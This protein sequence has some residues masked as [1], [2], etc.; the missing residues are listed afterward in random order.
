MEDKQY[1][2]SIYRKLVD[3]IP[4][5]LAEEFRISLTEG[6]LKFA[7]EYSLRKRINDLIRTIPNDFP[8]DIIRNRKNRDEF[9]RNISTTRTFIVHGVKPQGIN[10]FQGNMAVYLTEQ[11]RV[12]LE[13]LILAEL[14]M[15]YELIADIIY[16]NKHF[17]H[18][19]NTK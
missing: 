1:L 13:T 2:V 19:I 8:F 9:I 17:R 11:V 15:D 6:K 10:V 12:L 14:G 7:N 16:R 18:L 5:D 3:A 4:V